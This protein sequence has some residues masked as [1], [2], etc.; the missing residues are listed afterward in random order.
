MRFCL[1]YVQL[2]VLV[3][4]SVKYILINSYIIYSMSH[5]KVVT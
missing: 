1:F 2:L 5:L 3:G 4:S